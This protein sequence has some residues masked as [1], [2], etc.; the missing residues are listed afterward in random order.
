MQCAEASTSS[1]VF[2]MILP[3]YVRKFVN[4]GC[5]NATAKANATNALFDPCPNDQVDNRINR[6]GTLH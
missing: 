5:T 2:Q 4:P 1:P 3:D 6:C